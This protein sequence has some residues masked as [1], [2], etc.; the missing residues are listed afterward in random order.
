MT[1]PAYLDS[2]AVA[3]ASCQSPATRTLIVRQRAAATVGAC[4]A[5]LAG[6][7]QVY[8]AAGYVIGPA[9][10]LSSSGAV[11]VREGEHHG[12]KGVNA[13]GE[14]VTWVSR[15]AVRRAVLCE[16]SRDLNRRGPR[17]EVEG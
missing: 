2:G 4:D 14:A 1:G 17:T 7:G 15:Q 16:K 5:C 3:C 11:C 13:Q 6:M 9:C 12:C 8:L 10:E